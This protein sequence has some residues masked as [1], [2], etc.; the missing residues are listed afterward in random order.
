MAAVTLNKV[1][2]LAAKLTAEEQKQLVDEVK[3]RQRKHAAWLKQLDKDARQARADL[4]AGRLKAEPLD[5][6][7]KRLHNLADKEP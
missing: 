7:L 5:K 1:L 6:L 3:E 2:E 4:R